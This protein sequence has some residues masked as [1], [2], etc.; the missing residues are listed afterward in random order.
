MDT[1]DLGRIEVCKISVKGEDPNKVLA[2][3]PATSLARNHLL[4]TLARLVE[5]LFPGCN[6]RFATDKFPSPVP[7]TK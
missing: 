4:Q 7:R 1:K 6:Y 2:L 3:D 5:Y